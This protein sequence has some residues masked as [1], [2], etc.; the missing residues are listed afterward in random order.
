MRAPGF[1]GLQA[2][3]GRLREAMSGRGPIAEFGPPDEAP[4]YSVEAADSMRSL[5]RVPTAGHPDLSARPSSGGARV[6]F[7]RVLP[8]MESPYLVRHRRNEV[9]YVVTEG[10][11]QFLVDEDVIDAPAGTVLRVSPE[12]SRAWRNLSTEDFCLI[13]VQSRTRRTKPSRRP[14]AVGLTQPIR[15][16]R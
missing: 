7:A 5:Y 2:F 16:S 8:G 10:R 12:A 4:P 14:D 11:G 3:G 6:S 9:I 1:T 15:W 13:V